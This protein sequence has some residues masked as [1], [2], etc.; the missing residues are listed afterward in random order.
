MLQKDKAI[1]WDLDG[2]LADVSGIRH[3]ITAPTGGFDAFHRASEFVLPNEYVV[4][5]AREAHD[6]GYT[7]LIFSGRFEKYRVLST[8]WLE[9]NDVPYAHLEMRPD[10]DYR[11]DFLVKRDMFNAYAARYHITHAWDDRPAVIDLWNAIGLQVTV[12]PGWM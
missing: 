7:N 6:E 2:T 8:R 1:I 12:V 9:K 3:L 10:G 4:R 5:A 11:K